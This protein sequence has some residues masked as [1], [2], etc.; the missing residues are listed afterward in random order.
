MRLRSF[1]RFS[2]QNNADLF[3]HNPHNHTNVAIKPRDV[4]VSVFAPT[5]GLDYASNSCGESL[6]WIWLTKQSG[7]KSGPVR[8]YQQ[9]HW[10]NNSFVRLPFEPGFVYF[11]KL[12]GRVRHELRRISS[13]LFIFTTP[14]SPWLLL[15]SCL[16][17]SLEQSGEP[18]I[19]CLCGKCSTFSQ[20]QSMTQMSSW[21][22]VAAGR[23]RV[24]SNLIWGAYQKAKQ[25]LECTLNKNTV[26]KRLL[27]QTPQPQYLNLNR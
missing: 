8:F 2:S 21:R 6:D 12:I 26:G 17:T 24:S 5:F 19:C 4:I 13:G 18:I 7:D 25:H 22:H 27:I 15:N 1:T 16:T 3:E 14:F 10:A 23:V 20:S 9:S 11:F